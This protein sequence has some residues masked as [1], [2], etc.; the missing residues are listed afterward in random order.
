[1]FPCPDRARG[2]ALTVALALALAQTLALSEYGRRDVRHD[3]QRHKRRQHKH[4]QPQVPGSGSQGGS[5]SLCIHPP[6]LAEK[7]S[8][9]AVA[10]E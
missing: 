6:K 8:S 5:T 3:E 10:A 4:G 7:P 2:R 9:T 1:V